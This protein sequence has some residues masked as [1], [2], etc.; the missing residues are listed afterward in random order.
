M[1]A[2]LGVPVLPGTG[3]ADQPMVRAF[4][5]SLPPGAAMM[6]KAVHGGGGRGMRAVTDLA[7]IEDAFPRCGAEAEAAFGDG[8]LMA[9]R[10]IGRARRLGGQILGDGTGAAVHVGERECTLQ[11]RHQKVLEIAPSPSLTGAERD[12]LTGFALTLAQAGRYRGLGA[13]EFLMDLDAAPG[14]NLFF[15]EANPRIQVEHTVTEALF[16]LDLVALQLQVCGGATLAGLGVTQA[17]IGAPDGVAIQARVNLETMGA[18]GGATPAGGTLTAYD[19]P[20]GPGVRVDGFAYAGYATSPHYDSLLAKVIVH[21]RGDFASAAR[22]AGRALAEFC[23]EGAATNLPWLRALPAHD[24]VRANAV[25]TRFIEAEAQ[26]LDASAAAMA[27][28]L[29]PGAAP[30]AAQ[31]AEAIPEDANPMRA[32]MQA[33]LIAVHFAPGDAVRAGAEVAVLEAMKMQ[34][35]VTAPVAGTVRAALAAAGDTLADGA[36]VLLIDPS[37]DAQAE[38]VAAQ[39]VDLDHI[40]PDLAELRERLGAGLDANRPEAVAKRDARGQRTARENLG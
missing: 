16:G 9:E 14:A 6:I 18:D 11:P 4:F 40:R 35:S 3:E 28:P 32:P 26:A 8:A 19:P 30:A 38:D 36:V 23:I 17:S 27:A 22:K 25:T 15:I 20:S 29:F 10:F 12:V 21:A 39:E 31:A 13:F 5:A 1:A 37:G 2:D 7:Q 33:T 24:A 34:H